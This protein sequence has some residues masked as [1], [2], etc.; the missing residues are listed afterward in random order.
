MPSATKAPVQTPCSFLNK[1]AAAMFSAECAKLL[2]KAGYSPDSFGSY[3]YV[4][5]LIKDAKAAVAKYA[6]TA[7]PG[8]AN[9]GAKP[10]AFEAYLAGCQAG[11]LVQNAVFQTDRGNPCSNVPGMPGF[12]ESQ[13]PCMPQA[14]AATAPGGEHNLATLHE[15]ASARAAGAPG[16][17]YPAGQIEN[18]CANR[19]GLVADNQQLAAANGRSPLGVGGAEGAAAGG[20]AASGGDAGGAAGPSAAK[21]S[22]PPKLYNA[23]LT[24]QTAGECIDSF[25]KAGMQAM[26]DRCADDKERAK[27]L[28]KANPNNDPDGG[29]GYRQQLQE[30]ADLKAQQAAADPQNKAKKIAAANAQAAATKAQNAYCREAQGARIASGDSGD[31]NGIVPKNPRF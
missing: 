26:Q 19:A 5:G 21:P 25:R 12:D 23:P 4:K 31:G 6:A 8:K 14:G 9:P 11:H 30:R 16:A 18:D 20:G 15:Q 28:G 27:N 7:V 22:A 3:S 13:C 1:G 17:T 29:A 24:G 2:A 10:T